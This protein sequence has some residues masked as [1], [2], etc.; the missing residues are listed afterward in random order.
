MRI[1][2]F[3][4]AIGSAVAA[5][6]L[7]RG[8]VGKKQAP[9][10]KVVQKIQ[11]VDVLTAAKDLSVGERL[12]AGTLVWKAWPKG[13]IQ[14]A[15]ITRDEKPD[16]D[17][18]FAEARALTQIF[19]GET[20]NEKKVVQP[21]EGGFMSA[22]VPAGMRAVSIAVSNRLSAGGFIMP[23]DRVDVILTKKLRG[24]EGT[25]LIKSQTVITNVRVLAMNQTY[26]KSNDEDDVAI[27]EGEYA[28]LELTGDQVE[29]LAKV[30]S[31]GELS[32]ALRSIA[33][34]DGKAAAEGPQLTER[35]K[36]DGKG[37]SS[38]D[39]LFVRYGIET[40]ATNK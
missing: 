11:T 33:E 19:E 36:G 32:L 40:Y 3:G 4:L 38:G 26:R 9:E 2:M 24:P 39:T 8:M 22:I 20:I 5:A 21:G 12:S 14:D 23:N 37:L 28:T 34:G 29:V 31:E 27:K 18:S 17:A 10:A 25:D 13:N 1:L 35:Y 30:E 6:F 15:M 7:A 16:A